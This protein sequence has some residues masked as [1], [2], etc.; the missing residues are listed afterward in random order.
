MDRYPHRHTGC[1]GGTD[2]IVEHGT[3]YF[4]AWKHYHH[5]ANV[6]CDKCHREHLSACIGYNNQDLCLSCADQ[7]TRHNAPCDCFHSVRQPHQPH[8]SIHHRV[9]VGTP[10]RSIADACDEVRIVKD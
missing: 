2:R 9:H 3:Y 6:I 1:C 5:G 4:P 10:G 8:Q 7:M